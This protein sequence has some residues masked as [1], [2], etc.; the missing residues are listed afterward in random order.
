MRRKRLYALLYCEFHFKFLCTRWCFHTAMFAF[1]NAVGSKILYE[2]QL[3][4]MYGT[5]S[6]GNGEDE[7][8]ENYEHWQFNIGLAVVLIIT[9]LTLHLGSY[10][11]FTLIGW[12]NMLDMTIDL[13]QLLMR[14][15][16]GKEKNGR[17]WGLFSGSVVKCY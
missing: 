7:A 10:L 1:M 9:V 3:F 8:D 17:H 5:T 13:I 16:F 14:R 2:F 11:N 12:N 6:N 4:D 15:G